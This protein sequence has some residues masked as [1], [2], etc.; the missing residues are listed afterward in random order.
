ML[1]ISSILLDNEIIMLKINIKLS[2]SFYTSLDLSI[3]LL[4]TA[5]KIKNQNIQ[6]ITYF[7]Y[8][9][10]LIWLPLNC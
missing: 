6:G 7:E 10:I 4:Y 1:N 8:T 9:K 2:Y 3:C 5:A